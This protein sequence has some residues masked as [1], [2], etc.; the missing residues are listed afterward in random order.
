[1]LFRSAISE[2][3]CTEFEREAK[4]FN[5]RGQLV[6][7]STFSLVTCFPL[8]SRLFSRLNVGL[9]AMLATN[10]KISLMRAHTYSYYGDS[11]GITR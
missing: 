2:V 8:L 10:I 3:E 7:P 1:M 6:A 4:K 5:F 11:G 9:L